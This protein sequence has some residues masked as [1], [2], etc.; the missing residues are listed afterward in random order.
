MLIR[1]LS[2]SIPGKFNLPIEEITLLEG[3]RPQY[4]TKEEIPDVKFANIHKR[5][6]DGAYQHQVII[7]VL[8]SLNKNPGKLLGY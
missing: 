1:I 2:I 3:D 4:F 6:C 8:V 7:L 5:N